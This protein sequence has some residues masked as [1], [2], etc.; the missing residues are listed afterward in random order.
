M[1]FG[2][3]A[4]TPHTKAS[5][6]VVKRNKISITFTPGSNICELVPLK[7]EGVETEENGSKWTKALGVGTVWIQSKS[8]ILTSTVGT[9]GITRANFLNFTV[10]E[11]GSGKAV[12]KIFSINSATLDDLRGELLN[13]Q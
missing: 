12:K 3:L 8:L 6:F 11:T 4:Q 2:I 10:E 1:K 13:K 5:K 7:L 9:E